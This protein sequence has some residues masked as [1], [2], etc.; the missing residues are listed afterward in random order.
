MMQA[1]WPKD[2]VVLVFCKGGR[3]WADLV[4]PDLA[5]AADVLED[6]KAQAERQSRKE[7]LQRLCKEQINHKL[8]TH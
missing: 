8:V 2:G 7:S 5:N 4:S 3:Y 6:L 1:S